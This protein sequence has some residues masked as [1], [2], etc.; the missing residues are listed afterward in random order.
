MT[1]HCRFEKKWFIYS[2]SDEAIVQAGLP[3]EDKD[4]LLGVFRINHH[5]LPTEPSETDVKCIMK[6]Y[7]KPGKLEYRVQTMHGSF[8]R[9][10]GQ[11]YRVH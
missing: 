4:I 3:Q 8:I 10:A 2:D 5:K 6:M 7:K 11:I 9:G 1:L